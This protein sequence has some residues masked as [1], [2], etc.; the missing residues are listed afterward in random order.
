MAQRID[1][2]LAPARV[3]RKEHADG[4]FVLAS[5][6]PLDSYAS[7]ICTFLHHWTE[8]APTRT[9][10]AQRDD[11][12]AQAGTWR[13][14]NYAEALSA[15]RRLAAGLLKRWAPGGAPLML[16]SDNSIE[17][18]LAQF[19]G[20]YVGIPV[21]PIS[22]AYSLLS[23][24]HGR[25][26]HIA[27]RLRP[28]MVFTSDGQ[29]YARAL[30]ALDLDGVEVVTCSG[31]DELSA[32]RF[33]ALYADDGAAVDEA[34]AAVG[35]DTLAKIL[36]TSGSTGL[37]K[38]VENTQRMLC[39]NQEAIRQ[40]WP[41]L[42]ERPPV[43]V[44]WLPWNHTFGGNHNIGMVL[45]NGGAL[46]IDQGKPTPELIGKTIA[47]LADVSPTV[48]FNVP[49]GYAM[50]LPYLEADAALRDRFFAEMDLLFYSG[51]ALP[52]DL[53]TR[54][55][56]L[57]LESR[58]AVVPITSSWGSTETAPA[59]TSAHFPIDQAGNIGIPLPGTEIR[60]VPSGSK[61]EIRVRGPQVTPGYYRDPQLT[62]EAFDDEGF[63]R[64][65]DAGKLADPQRPEKG[66]I[67]DGRIAEDFKLL[68]G[69]W[70]ST[71]K[72]R[73]AAIDAASPLV[74]DAVVAGHDRDEIGLLLFLNPSAC[75]AFLHEHGVAGADP[76][77]ADAAIRDHIRAGLAAY[78][79]SHPA[80]SERIARALLLTEPP[81]IDDNEIT[82]KGYINQRTVLER[83]SDRVAE[84]FDNGA[85]VIVL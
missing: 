24:D 48:Y 57:S 21:A 45:R 62:R 83:R 47:S 8:V 69:T 9:F 53:W 25:L 22:P 51:A 73:I 56:K 33:D 60:F 52:H 36:F 68:T 13:E 46:Y 58:G 40:A 44:D 29:L 4:G 43:L 80:S 54:L 39:S 11:A 65:G 66:I 15:V 55:E 70:V 85:A 81:S 49:R 76:P 42:A 3:E 30:A 74:Q 18:A 23:Q 34:F 12:L 20:M 59:A 1:L 6:V 35:P 77:A 10:L 71:G 61:F 7:N 37:P 63:Y 28:R 38:G 79:R 67:F 5:P 75:D 2:D 41:F 64:I 78:N 82:D 27:E 84:L 17:H 26:R 32:T 31:A 19:A 72:V 16:L 50:L 14:L